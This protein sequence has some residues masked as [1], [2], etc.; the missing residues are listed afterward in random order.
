LRSTAIGERGSLQRKTLREAKI[1]ADKIVFQAFDNATISALASNYASA[2]GG[3]G[4]YAGGGGHY[5]GGGGHYGGGG[6]YGGCQHNSPCLIDLCH[7]HPITISE[8]LTHS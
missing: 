1:T 5:G 2:A 6:Y 3:G 4:H 7:C 8:H